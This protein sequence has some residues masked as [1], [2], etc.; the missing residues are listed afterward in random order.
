MMPYYENIRML[1]FVTGTSVYGPFTDKSDIDI[2]MTY[3]DADRLKEQLM[4]ASFE[5]REPNKIINP[6]YEGFEFNIACRSFNVICVENEKEY[7]AW[8]YAT[9]QML[10]ENE[11][12]DRKKRIKLFT[13]YKEQYLNES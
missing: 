9:N 2:V 7:M 3:Y 8:R 13:S 4:K 11:I 5:I 10:Y 6:V 1:P 12:K